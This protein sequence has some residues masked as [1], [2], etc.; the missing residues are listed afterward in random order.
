[1][2]VG[3]KYIALKNYLARSQAPLITLTFAQIEEIIGFELPESATKHAEAWW[4]N[5]RDH[6]QAVAWLDAG[7]ETDWVS[8]SY[9]NKHITFQK[10]N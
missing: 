3:D 8:D 6:S 5:N 10:V 9:A 2:P 1:M 7:Y 4:S